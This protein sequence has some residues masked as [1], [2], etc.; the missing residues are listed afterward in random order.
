MWKDLKFKKPL[1]LAVAFIML[2][3]LLL[4][5]CKESDSDPG[6]T[7]EAKNGGSETEGKDPEKLKPYEIVWYTIGTPQKDI[8]VVMEELSKYTKDK[9]NATVKMTQFDWG[10][11]TDKMNIILQ[12]GEPFD[13]A[14]TCSW[15]LNY[16]Q[17]V[18]KKAFLPLDDLLEEYGKGIKQILHPLFIEGNRIDGKLY[19]I[20]ANK[21]LSPQYRW[22]FNK[23][24]VDKYNMDLSKVSD[25][26][27]LEPLLKTIKENEKDIEVI[28]EP[29]QDASRQIDNLAGNRIP[30]VVPMDS[31]DYKVVNKY[32]LP[33]VIKTLKTNRRYYEAG[34]IRKDAAT[35]QGL[36][37]TK[38][39]KWFVRLGGWLPGAD[40]IWSR[41]GKVPAVSVPY[42]NEVYISNSHVAGSMMAISVTSADPARVMMFLDMLNTDKY[43]RNM[44][45]SGIENVHYKMVNDRQVD[46][47]K[48]TNDYNMPS[49]TLGNRFICNL[50]ENDDADQWDQFKALNTSA[51]KSPILGFKANLD[52]IKKEISSF[53]NI[54]QEF[55]PLLV[56]G[57]VDVD[58]TLSKYMNKLKS[59]GYDKVMNELQRQLDDWR[60]QN[61]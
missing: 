54:Y 52:P 36:D 8:E 29:I 58:D 33:S 1:A 56:T 34:Y 47:D 16:E 53:E 12:S 18:S 39:D 22:V 60:E 51:K 4:T 23:N 48:G 7:T 21:E 5:G 6:S 35:Y 17:M 2:F 15:A 55:G 41:D 20:A 61:R 11:Y 13:I 27:S 50:Y 19:A 9:I 32:E 49:F 45:D 14:F 31:T 30:F 40:Q 24:L 28:F 26:E 57:T 43:V 37:Y 44:V 46:L 38:T 42:Y 59:S 10:K 3:A 25:K